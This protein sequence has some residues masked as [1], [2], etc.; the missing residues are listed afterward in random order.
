M[1]R[2]TNLDA[3]QLEQLNAWFVAKL[4]GGVPAS[5]SDLGRAVWGDVVAAAEDGDNE[6][7]RLLVTLSLDGHEERAYTFLKS[8]TGTIVVQMDD[9]AAMAVRSPTRV[10]VRGSRADGSP[11]HQ[12]RLWWEVSW[13]EYAAWRDAM[14]A[15][16]RK[17]AMKRYAFDRI[18]ALREAYPETQT[19]GEACEMAGI[20]P[21]SL[22]MDEV[23]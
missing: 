15:L 16:E 7:F 6:A 22:G 4:A 3:D 23:A 14:F 12:L 5:R 1:S 2:K 17:I 10:G 18:D 11:S 9:G 8:D 19:P 20:D 21:R 13:Q